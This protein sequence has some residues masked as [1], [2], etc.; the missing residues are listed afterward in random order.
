MPNNIHFE[1]IIFH[2]KLLNIGI[3]GLEN[4]GIFGLENIR[5]YF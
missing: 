2:E 1:D 5:K 3:F 4:I